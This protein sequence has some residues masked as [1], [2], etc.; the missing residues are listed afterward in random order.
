MNKT[1]I[2]DIVKSVIYKIFIS[3]FIA[4][5]TAFYKGWIMKNKKTIII[6]IVLLLITSAIFYHITFQKKGTS[7]TDSSIQS[8]SISNSNSEKQIENEYDFL[9]QVQYDKDGKPTSVID[10]QYG[11]TVYK[12][13][14]SDTGDLLNVTYDYGNG[15]SPY[16]SY[17]YTSNGDVEKYYYYDKL[18][19]SYTYGDNNNI[20]SH[21]KYGDNNNIQLAEHYFYEDN[22]LKG[23]Y[24][25]NLDLDLFSDEDV[26]VMSSSYEEFDSR[27]NTVKYTYFSNDEEGYIIYKYDDNLE[28][29]EYYS[30]D[31]ILGTV[32]KIYYDNFGN[33]TKQEYINS[34]GEI[35]DVCYYETTIDP[36][37]NNMISVQ[38]YSTET[39]Y[40]KTITDSNKKIVSEGSYDEYDTI[41][42]LFEYY[43]DEFNNVEKIVK[44]SDGQKQTQYAPEREYYANGIIKSETYYDGVQYITGFSIP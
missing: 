29:I 10:N 24:S 21:H 33:K 42:Y 4:E 9:F 1:S 38:R 36:L 14:Y 6:I 13:T 40:H 43:Y 16:K 18:K 41:I 3:Y 44:T 12:Y 19:E 5:L 17:V 32:H 26:W 23:I 2:Y 25:Y 7:N 34:I 31:G 22:V 8:E 39:N 28:V 11:H 27:G 15:P 30:L 37:T 35:S 20:I